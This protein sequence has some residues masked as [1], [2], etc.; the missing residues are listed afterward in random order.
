MSFWEDLSPAVKGVLVIGVIGIIVSVLMLSG[1][2]ELGGDDGG[3]GEA[4]QRGFSA[5]RAT[6]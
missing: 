2:I 6:E 5:D 4:Q 3:A 1:V